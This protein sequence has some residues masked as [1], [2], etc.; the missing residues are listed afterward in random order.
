MHILSV[1]GYGKAN[2][3]VVHQ[4]SNILAVSNKLRFE[5]FK[6][7]E[8]ACQYCGRKTPEAI[9]EIDHIIPISKGGDDDLENLTT[10]CFECN[11]GKGDS[12]LDTILKGRDIHEESVLLAERERQLAEYNYLR[13][14]IREREDQEIQILLDHFCGQFGYPEYADREFPRD[15]VRSA[16]KLIS[17]IDIMDLIDYAVS[18]TAKDPK[19][20]YHNVAA[21][22]Y[23]TAI[24]RNKIKEAKNKSSLEPA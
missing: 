13:Q 5:V 7:D 18:K 6:R 9:L 8:F 11:R 15:F 24:L 4:R 3:A 19:G 23:L 1:S 12:L 10:S 22:K 14:K 2:S 17:Y 16:L 20:D 21:A